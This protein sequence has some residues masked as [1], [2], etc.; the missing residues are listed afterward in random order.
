MTEQPPERVVIRGVQPELECGR[1]QIKRVTGESIVVEADIFADGHE[2]IA[3]VCRYRREDDPA[4]SE[5]PMDPLWNDRWR[6]EFRVENL[7]QYIYTITAW[8]DSFK[9]W[10]NDFRKRTAAGQDV[11]IDLLIGKDLLLSAAD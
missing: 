11:T 1:F 10:Y 8:I 2:S 4:W 7:G 6:A 9:T 3:A 5:V